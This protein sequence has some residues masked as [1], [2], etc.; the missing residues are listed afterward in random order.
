MHIGHAYVV[1]TTNLQYTWT[2]EPGAHVMNVH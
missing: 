2:L 1:N